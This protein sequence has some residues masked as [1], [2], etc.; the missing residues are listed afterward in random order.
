VGERIALEHL[1]KNGSGINRM[2]VACD[3]GDVG[4][5]RAAGEDHEVVGGRRSSSQFC[6][7]GDGLHCVAMVGDGDVASFF[8]MTCASGDGRGREGEYQL[9]VVRVDLD[10]HSLSSLFSS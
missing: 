2:Q 4:A 5:A 6:A 7:C 8:R 3:P 1:S 10:I 9:C